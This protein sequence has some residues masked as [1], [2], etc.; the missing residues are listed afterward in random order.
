MRRDAGIQSRDAHRQ[1]QLRRSGADRAPRSSCAQAAGDRSDPRSAQGRA[2]EPA[3]LVSR[4]GVDSRLPAPGRNAEARAAQRARHP[5][6][7]KRA[8]DRR[9]RCLRSTVSRCC[10]CRTCTSTSTSTFVPALI[11]R[12]RGVDYDVC[13]MTGDYRSKTYGPSTR[14]IDGMRRIRA[15][16]HDPIYA[17]ARQSRQHPRCVPEFEAMGIRMLMNESVDAAPRRC[18]ARDWSAST[19]HHFFRLGRHSRRSIAGVP[20]ELPSILLSHTPEVYR[21]AAEAGFDVMLCGHTHGGQI[22]LPGGY[23]VTLDARHSAAHRARAVATGH[24]RLHVAR[25]RHVDRRRA[26]QLSAGDHAA[27]VARRMP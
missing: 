9:A 6:R 21:Q 18:A 19:M 2:D 16:L 22:C 10:I 27:S 8:A 15:V 20:A 23:P 7:R 25:R 26:D 14:R 3:R 12:L 5:H 17:R 4:A 1:R 13:V 11:E 24:G